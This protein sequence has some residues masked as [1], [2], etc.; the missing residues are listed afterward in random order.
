MLED[1]S[2]EQIK[3]QIQNNK[4]LKFALYGIGGLLVLVLGYFI[5]RQFVTVPNNEKS[6]ESYIAGLN[7]AVAD[8]TN[9]AIDELTSV[10]KKNDGYIG[11]EVAQFVLARQLMNK[12][13]FESALKELQG[14]VVNDTYV[15]S[16]A[17]GLQGDCESELGNYAKAAN[18]Y[19]EAA[20]ADENDFTTPM[21]LFKSAQ[22]AETKEVNNFEKSFE[23]YTR[24]KDD[25]PSYA[26]QKSIDKYIERAA[27]QK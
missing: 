2:G 26:A 5:Y 24:I 23:L 6:K 8:S 15:K 9:M 25:F 16:M 10:V 12:G 14:V 18:L 21:Y 4:N 17:I 13:E 22:C 19:L 11:G 27:A 3:H 20:D 7:Y 1:I